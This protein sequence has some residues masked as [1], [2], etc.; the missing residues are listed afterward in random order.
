MKMKIKKKN[1]GATDNFDGI[2]KPNTNHLP[3]LKTHCLSDPPTCSTVG[4]L[5]EVGGKIEKGVSRKRG[6]DLGGSDPLPHY[7]LS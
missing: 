3:V 1:I 4:F 5:R 7:E 6:F 2:G